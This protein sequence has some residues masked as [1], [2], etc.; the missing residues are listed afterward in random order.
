MVPL[1]VQRGTVGV[2]ETLPSSE[3]RKTYASLTEPTSVTV[4]GRPLGT[5]YPAGQEPHPAPVV[6]VQGILR[7]VPLCP[8]CDGRLRLYARRQGR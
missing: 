1:S 6:D 2:M 7:E 8:D 4:D 3:F 5:F